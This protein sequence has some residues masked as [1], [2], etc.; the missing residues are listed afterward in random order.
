MTRPLRLE[1]AG[2][3]Y[4]VT[5]R[6]DRL[7]DIF[8]DQ[9]DRF[10][11]LDLL[12]KVCK[13]Y[14]FIIH[15]FCQMTNHYHLVVETVNGGLARGMRQLNGTYS[16]HFNQRHALVGHVFQGRYHAVL[17]QRE[18]YL[19]ELSR[20]VVLNPIRAGMASTLDEWSWSSYPYFMRTDG[21]PQWL[22]TDS[23]LSYFGAD[24]TAARRAFKEF[25]LNGRGLLSPLRNVQHQLLLGDKDFVAE[26][27]GSVEP[28]ALDNV[29][30]THRQA[31]VLTLD[32]YARQ[33]HRCDEAMA[34]AYG[35]MGYSMREIARHFGTSAKT[36]GRAV[37]HFKI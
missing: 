34:R 35:S 2:A 12:A 28:D 14:N 21:N 8:R 19:L 23:L 25:V 7:H 10:V 17:V 3:L 9:A 18:N 24:R 22:D 29:V 6:G 31:L 15:S 36:V 11:W 20:Y 5:S 27:L 1:F 32:D 33:Y 16:Q 30:R 4:H 13:R 37:K 26:H